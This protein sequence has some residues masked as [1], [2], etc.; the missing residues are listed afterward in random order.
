[1]TVVVVTH[2]EGIAQAAEQRVVLRDVRIANGAGHVEG[3]ER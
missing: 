1:M 2:D 3:R